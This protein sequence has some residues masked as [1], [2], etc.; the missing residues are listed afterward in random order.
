MGTVNDNFDVLQ[1]WSKYAGEGW[2]N[3]YTV[4]RYDEYEWRDYKRDNI[5]GN[6]RSRYQLWK[7]EMY[8]WQTFKPADMVADR[9]KM[10]NGALAE[11]ARAAKKRARALEREKN[12]GWYD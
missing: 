8:T 12:P 9:D 2:E 6:E 10:I 11:E 5:G 3:G 1:T 7:N 4:K